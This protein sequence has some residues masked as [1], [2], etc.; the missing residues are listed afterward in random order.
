VGVAAG[1]DAVS[2][3]GT[4]TGAGGRSDRVAAGKSARGLLPAVAGGTFSGD[5]GNAAGA[6]RTAAGSS[7]GALTR[8]SSLPLIRWVA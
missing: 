2:G 5:S 1:A 4:G 7:V 3:A 6:G 8:A